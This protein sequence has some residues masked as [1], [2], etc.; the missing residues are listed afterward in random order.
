MQDYC[1]QNY[2]NAQKKGGSH[3]VTRRRYNSNKKGVDYM[4]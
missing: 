3:K 1:M 2:G 4:A